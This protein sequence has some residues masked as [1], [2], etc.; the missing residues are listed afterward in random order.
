MRLFVQFQHLCLVLLTILSSGSP[1]LGES[2]SPNVVLI[3]VD[4]LRPELN[5][6]GVQHIR[7]PNIDALAATGEDF[8]VDIMFRPQPVELH[9]TLC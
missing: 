1:L 4:D 7:S 2:P 3:C 5:C 9:A 6:Y 8:S